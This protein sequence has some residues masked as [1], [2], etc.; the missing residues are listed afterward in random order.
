VTDKAGTR[1]ELRIEFQDPGK[2]QH[3]E[4]YRVTIGT[5]LPAPGGDKAATFAPGLKVDAS[6]TVT[7]PG[8][9]EVY[10][11]T[12]KSNL[13][14]ILKVTPTA[15]P[16]DPA[17]KAAQLGQVSPF[18]LEIRKAAAKVVAKQGG[19]VVELDKTGE[20]LNTGLAPMAGVL[21]HAVLF[22]KDGS[23]NDP[24]TRALLRGLTLDPGRPAPLAEADGSALE[25]PLPA[26]G[27]DLTGKMLVL[28]LSAVG[29]GPGNVVARAE[30]RV[31]IPNP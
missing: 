6:K 31:E 14:L 20:L 30:R 13:G 7:I 29:A 12:T 11:D 15:D 21:L 22:A 24:I 1:R 9:L 18:D 28:I 2:E 17:A 26:D 25:I 5:D 3:P 16:D 10:T 19:K 4:R 27:T 23:T 8:R